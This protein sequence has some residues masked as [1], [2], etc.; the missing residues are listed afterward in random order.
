MIP[1]QLLMAKQNRIEQ[2]SSCMDKVLKI[3]V[4]DGNQEIIDEIRETMGDRYV[5]SY[6]EFCRKNNLNV[7]LT[8]K[9]MSRNK[10]KHH[11]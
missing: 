1:V 6:I 8:V 3:A 2:L 5:D 7:F 10:R 4:K 11:Q 9:Y